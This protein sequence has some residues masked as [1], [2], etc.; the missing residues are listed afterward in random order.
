MRT[1]EKTTG[2]VEPRRGPAR[3]AGQWARRH[4]AVTG[5]GIAAGT[6]L[7]IFVLV[8]FQPQK[9]FIDDRVDEAPPA[10]QAPPATS[11]PTTGPTD[12]SPTGPVASGTFRS[13]AHTT[14]GTATLVTLADGTAY[15]RL[16]P[17]FETEN[18]PDLFVYLSPSDGSGSND[19]AIA[20]G[21]L[22]LG[23]LRGNIGAQNYKI[24]SGTDLSRYNSVLIWCDRFSTGFGVASL[25]R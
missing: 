20:K 18:G 13:L 3:R 24:P 25:K 17:G 12:A 14:K 21:S 4:P 2:Q 10:A 9:L 5:V 6:G 19:D 1:E 8:W 7:L 15:V 11:A 22:N 16:E 23:K